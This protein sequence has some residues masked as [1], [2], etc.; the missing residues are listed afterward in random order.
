MA[1]QVDVRKQ[2]QVEHWIA[3][4]VDTFKRLDGGVN[5]AGV[6]GGDG[7]T[8]VQTMVCLKRL[9][10]F[11]WTDHLFCW[12]DNSLWEFTIGVN[13]TGVMHCMRA[14]LPHLSRP[15]GSIVNIASISGV[16][17]HPKSSAYAAS[18]HGVVGLTRSAAGEFGEEGI[19]VNAVLPGPID[20]AIYRD[21]E[22]KGLWDSSTH[23]AM[24]AMKRVG[25]AEE[26]AKVICFLLSDDASYVTA[27]ECRFRLRTMSWT[28][29]RYS[30]MDC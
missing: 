14:Q 15:G 20:T 10:H 30:S 7:D 8:N 27:G 12:Q 16:R 13:L 22:A 18:K 24:T 19:R 17:G 23:S 3:S 4:A 5:A 29:R 26:V 11:I 6:A 25:K 1:A 28:D 2:E 9:G 21:G